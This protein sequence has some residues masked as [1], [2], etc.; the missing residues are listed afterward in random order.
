MSMPAF[1]FLMPAFSCPCTL[2]PKR[3]L[4]SSAVL[5][6]KKYDLGSPVEEPRERLYRPTGFPKLT[7]VRLYTV[8]RQDGL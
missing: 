1:S 7:E 4:T 5:L 3:K 6:A 8:D 2:Q